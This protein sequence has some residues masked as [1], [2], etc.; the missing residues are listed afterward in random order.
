MTRVDPRTALSRGGRRN[1]RCWI[2]APWQPGDEHLH[3][4]ISNF[5][6][7]WWQAHRPG[8]GRIR[9]VDQRW[10]ARAHEIRDLLTRHNV[11]FDFVDVATEEGRL[12]VDQFHVGDSKLPAVIAFSVLLEYPSNLQIVFQ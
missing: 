11:R 10:S 4:G 9:I 7:Q 8:L 6:Y 2:A 5:L 1:S 12:I 3:Q